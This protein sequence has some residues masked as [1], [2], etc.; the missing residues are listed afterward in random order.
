VPISSHIFAPQAHQGVLIISITTMANQDT[1][2]LQDVIIFTGEKTLPDGFVFVKE[3]K[4]ESFGAGEPSGI[5]PGT[6]VISKPG[7]TVLPGFIDSHIH[8]F[9][10]NEKALSTALHYGITT[11]LD[12]HL[13]PESV[14]KLRALLKSPGAAKKYADFRT[15]GLSA[16]VAEGYPVD[17]SLRTAVY[18][19]VLILSRLFAWLQTVKKLE[20]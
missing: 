1:F 5:A 18:C 6:K 15:A 2:V 3:G 10:G 17:V 4:I 9:L 19:Y 13:E 11:A 7:H 12:M 14:N 8:A 16:T 20:K